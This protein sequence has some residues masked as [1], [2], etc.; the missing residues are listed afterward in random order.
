MEGKRADF[1]GILLIDTLDWAS[2]LIIH[3]H[4]KAAIFLKQI[5]FCHERM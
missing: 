2:F 3:F 1:G 5:H 4:V